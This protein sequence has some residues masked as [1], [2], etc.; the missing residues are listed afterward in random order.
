MRSSSRSPRSSN[1]QSST[2]LAWAGAPDVPTVAET[3][4]GYEMSAWFGFAAPKGTPKEMIA[5]LNTEA[6]RALASE[7]VRSRFTELG[8]K[9]GGGSPQDFQKRI[10]AEVEKWPSVVKAT[11]FQPQ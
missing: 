7:I 11:G 9:P 10:V 4:P 8:M 3:V 2:F 5:K 1:G 6:N